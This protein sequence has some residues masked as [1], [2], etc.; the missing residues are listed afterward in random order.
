MT[1]SLNSENRFPESIENQVSAASMFTETCL[2][3]SIPGKG[4]LCKQPD[5]MIRRLSPNT[6]PILHSI[7]IH[8]DL[9][10]FI[11]I[12][13]DFSIGRGWMPWNRIVHADDFQ[14]FLLTT[15]P[16]VNI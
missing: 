13:E 15:S 14:G 8:T 16:E 4:Y 3:E 7:E 5:T 11:L 9:L 10:H 12:L 6:Q 1:S 2:G